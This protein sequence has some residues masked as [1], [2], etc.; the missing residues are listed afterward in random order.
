VAVAEFGTK[1]DAD[2]A[3]ARLDAAGI[4]ASS[5]YDPALNTVAPYFASDRVVEVL[6]RFRD[7]GPAREVLGSAPDVLPGEFALDWEPV[8]WRARAWARGCL[9]VLLAVATG[10]IAVALVVG[11]LR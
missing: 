3:V 8:T 1:F 4:R 10:V 6:V 11:A 7:L 5:S 9:L 2:A